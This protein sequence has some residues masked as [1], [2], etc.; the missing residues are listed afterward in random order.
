MKKIACLILIG[1]FVLVLV[2][3]AEPTPSVDLIEPGDMV[4]DMV[5]VKSDLE[6]AY[7]N[8]I[9]V[10]KYCYYYE[11]YFWYACE[12]VHGDS[13]FLNC[14]GWVEDT[15]EEL[16]AKWDKSTWEM[17][18]DGQIVD[19]PKFGFIQQPSYYH[20][21]K[22]VGVWG[23]AIENLTAGTHK[24]ICERT[25]EGGPTE[26]NRVYVTVSE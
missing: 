13:L 7:Y 21:G 14:M 20:P 12:A 23:V 26:T 16:E 19:L 3:C 11:D 8:E 9:L 25:V 24:I 2:S 1:W 22:F 6:S 4:N 17:T 10:D 5:I 15:P 18:I